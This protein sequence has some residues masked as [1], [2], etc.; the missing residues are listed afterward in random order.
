M[1]IEYVPALFT[2]SLKARN[3]V[4]T[5]TGLLVCCIFCSTIIAEGQSSWDF[6]EEEEIEG[7]IIHK[8]PCE[9]LSRTV[10]D[11][12][13]GAVGE[14][15]IGFIKE[16]ADEEDDILV[17][18][19][20][21]EMLCNVA[22]TALM[23]IRHL[24]SI[25]DIN[26]PVNIFLVSES[27]FFKEME[28][29]LW[30]EALSVDGT[31]YLPHQYLE[32]ENINKTIHH[33]ILHAIVYHIAGNRVPAW[34]EEGLAQILSGQVDPNAQIPK[35]NGSKTSIRSLRGGSSYQDKDEAD[36]AYSIAVYAVSTLA[37]EHGFST[38]G[39]YLS[40]LALGYSHARAF[41]TAFEETEEDLE[42][43]ISKSNIGRSRGTKQKK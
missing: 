20:K 31:I 43:R 36:L 21:Y 23:Q 8:R 12:S 24:L 37:K 35:L 11:R 19:K 29:P 13:G 40:K 14:I 9:I 6:F 41:Q 42:L 38:F 4:T 7:S 28:A 16:F 30:A 2:S 5:I 34:L 25:P 18:V 10:S 17:P 32:A 39:T 15:T 1:E 26:I 33:E 27:H 22:S 3:I